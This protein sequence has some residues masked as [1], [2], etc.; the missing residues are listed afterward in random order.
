M[1]TLEAVEWKFEREFARRLDQEDLL[2]FYRNQFYFPQYQG[3][4][5]LYFTGNSLG[6]QPV[7]ARTA[8]ERELE[9]WARWGV[10]GH[11]KATYPWYS[12]HEMFKEALAYLTG[13]KRD[14]VTAM[15]SLTAN[16]HFLMASFYRPAGRRTKILYEHKA[17]PSDIYAI[18]SQILFH[19]L[20]P[21]EN[22]IEVTPD[23]GQCI[24][25]DRIVSTIKENAKELAL[26]LLGG[27]NYYTGQRFDMMKVAEAAKKAGAFVGLDLAHAIGNVELELHDWEVDFAV[28][29][30]YKY[31]NS[32]PGSV[33]GLFV[34]EKH[35]DN[36]QLPRLAGWWGYPADRRFHME[37]K[38][39]PTYGADGWQLSNAPVFS[40]AV[41]KVALDMFLEAT[42]PRLFE[43]RD[44][45]TAYLEY[46]LTTLQQRYP[47][48]QFQLI[49]P[50]DK[51]ERGS[52]LSLFMQKNGKHLFEFLTDHGVMADWREPDVMRLAPVPM[53]N[54]FEDVYRLGKII[55]KYATR[56]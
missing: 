11:M 4:K 40:M 22:M 55:E 12:Y 47:S 15:G 16:L 17:F 26:V 49:T 23:K 54:S 25:T 44:R 6:L 34:H 41:H 1:N 31:L 3:E 52:Q 35:A 30:S 33:A 5:V 45:L 48:L 37:N 7:M 19:G 24:S 43:K 10:E 21:S 46:V 32:G 53:Y 9:D 13:A 18:E 14:E 51:M 29:C 20:D 38:F 27:V 42:L 28:W 2:N 8:L 36:S 39:V 56:I 50:A